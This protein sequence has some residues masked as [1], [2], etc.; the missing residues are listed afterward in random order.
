MAGREEEGEEGVRS[1]QRADDEGFNSGNEEEPEG[2]ELFGDDV[3]R[4]A[5]RRPLVRSSAPMLTCAPVPGIAAT[6]RPCRTLTPTSMKALWTT[7]TSASTLRKK[8]V[9][10]CK[11]RSRLTSVTPVRAEPLVAVALE[12]LMVR[13]RSRYM[14]D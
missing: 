8:L 7:R 10:A 9:P 14:T 3:L 4:C 1:Q 13:H 11:P 12:R 5:P 2:E 6:T